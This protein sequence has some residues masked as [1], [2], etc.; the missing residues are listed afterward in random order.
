MICLKEDLPGELGKRQREICYQALTEVVLETREFAQLLGDI[1]SDCQ[2]IKGAVEQRLKLIGL[3]NEQDFLKHITLVA[4]RTAE[5]QSRVT[6]AALLFHL[7]EDYD[8]VIQIVNDAV[9]LALTTE[10]GEQ[11]A[12]LT[13]LKP[14]T[15]EP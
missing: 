4:A 3:E 11:P 8:K 13:P 6:D 9:S 1:R 2:R 12:R 7:A 15:T 10:L 5:E 14:R